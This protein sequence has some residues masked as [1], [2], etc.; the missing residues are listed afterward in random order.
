MIKSINFSHKQ[1]AL[2]THFKRLY[3]VFP[4]Q[5]WLIFVGMFFSTVGASMVWPFMT[6][7][8][9]QK[10]DI[11][12]TTVGWLMMLN[13]VLSLVFAFLAGS[14]ADKIGRKWI[15]VSGLAV[16]ALGYLFMGQASTLIE[17]V[18]FFGIFGG[19]G[20]I[21]RVGADAMVADL[22][23][24]NFRAEAY[25]VL[26]LSQNVGVAMG[27]AIGGFLA[28]IS[29]SI[30]FFA[31]AAGLA[32]F[33]ILS[34]IFARET[35]PKN[36]ST[37]HEKVSGSYG[38]VFRDTYFIVYI[39]FM[40]IISLAPSLI[41]TLMA[42]YAKTQYMIPE[43]RFGFIPTT[44]ALLVVFLQVPI[45]NLVKKYHPLLSSALG[46]LLFTLGVFSV[47][48]SQNFYGFLL[49]MIIATFGELIIIPTSTNYSA[50][51]SPLNMRGRYMSIY[52]LTW[53]I[54]YGIGPLLGGYLYDEI[55]P[56]SVWYIG[57]LIGLISVLGFVAMFFRKG[58]RA[59]QEIHS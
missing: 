46:A 42:V 5:F 41:W 16:N 48:F 30:A 22:I 38:P 32:I 11:N 17:V 37:I 8:I 40:T 54:A 39:V 44:N 33:S 20:T 51:L 3:Q 21:Y 59:V 31:G 35:M 1:A 55:S 12:L 6:I 28:G 2:I 34:L 24:E 9:S 27:P 19:F 23:P 10:L 58:E 18:V 43:S 57:G 14:L 50:Y 29:Y 13:S 52:S 7:Y 36:A 26:R 25:S 53:G 45:T 4:R 47:A 15:I 56:V 49:S